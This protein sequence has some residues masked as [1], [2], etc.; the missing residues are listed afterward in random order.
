M[1]NSNQS[2][3]ILHIL[4][5]VMKHDAECDEIDKLLRIPYSVHDALKAYQTLM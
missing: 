2:L 1:E 4:E 5:L 3:K